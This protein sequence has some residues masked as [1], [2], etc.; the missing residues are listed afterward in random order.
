MARRVKT[1]TAR[2][3]QTA[4]D[5]RVLSGVSAQTAAPTL[6]TE[7]YVTQGSETALLI[8]K[9]GGTTPSF[10]IQVYLYSDVSGTWSKGDLHTITEDVV[11]VC[12][13][14]GMDRIMLQ[15]AANATGT[16]PT[17]DAWVALVLPV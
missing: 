17:L 6:S 2:A 3:G 5:R 12:M 11:R 14:G 16:L 4:N 9:V 10:Q 13:H 7:G 15:V 8:F 1:T